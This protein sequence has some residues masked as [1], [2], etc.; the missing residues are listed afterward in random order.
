[1]IVFQ[2]IGILSCIAALAVGIIRWV[3]PCPVSHDDIARQGATK[4]PRCGEEV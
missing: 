2:I 4:C 3:G 1:M